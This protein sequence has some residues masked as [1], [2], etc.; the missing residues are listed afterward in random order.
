MNTNVKV[1]LDKKEFERNAYKFGI[2]E[3]CYIKISRKD[4]KENSLTLTMKSS[5]FW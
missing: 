5:D 3:K 1:V 4:F 2:F